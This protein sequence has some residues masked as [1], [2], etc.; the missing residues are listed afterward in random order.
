MNP[1]KFHLSV[2]L[3]QDAIDFV[4]G[5]GEKH[6]SVA[7]DKVI[8]GYR[9]MQ[10]DHNRAMALAE[11]R[12]AVSKLRLECGCSKEAISAWARTAAREK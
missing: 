4:N 6:F 8:K 12:A 9:S 7:L 5:L 10:P 3:S 11:L 2:S 1:R